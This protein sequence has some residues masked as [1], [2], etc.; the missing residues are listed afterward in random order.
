MRLQSERRGGILRLVL[1]RTE[2]AN[3]YDRALLTELDG[4]LE[5]A[6]ANP[7]AVLLLQSA[8]EGAF[9]AGADQKEQTST[10]F[11]EALSLQSQRVFTRLARLPAVS[12]AAIQGAAVG[13]GL[14]LA[15]AC[16]LRVAGPK[17]R[18]WLPE[19]ALGILPAA[20]GCSRLPALIGLSRAKE[21]ILGGRVL[22]APTAL[23][24]GLVHRLA[25]D[26]RAEAQRWAEELQT[27]DSVAQRWAKGL[28]EE[29]ILD[30]SLAAERT[31]AAMLYARRARGPTRDE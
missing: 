15:L 12:I 7:P 17:A 10:P 31:V 1:D 9:C 13:G 4:S 22:D 24:W 8:G 21:L 29:E 23:S 11:L 16:D 14:E 5:E 25:D 18:F 20:G 27:R 2:R 30:R 28:L 19:T 26:P 3:A 6:E